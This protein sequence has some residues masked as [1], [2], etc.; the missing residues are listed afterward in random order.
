MLF[1]AFCLRS[2]SISPEVISSTG[3]FYSNATAMISFTEGEPLGEMISSG[4]NMI[5]Q[6]FEQSDISVISVEE[7]LLGSAFFSLFPNPCNGNFK[8]RSEKTEIKELEIY[9]VIGEKVYSYYNESVLMN[10]LFISLS[11]NPGIY[12]VVV[13]NNGE[14]ITKKLVI[15]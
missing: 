8:F 2:Q 3:D 7:I 5:T 14:Q 4:N 15:Q 10:E 1:F 12:F 6:G 9:N 11:S 13:K